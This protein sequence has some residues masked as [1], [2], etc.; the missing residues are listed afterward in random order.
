M[1]IGKYKYYFR[2]PRSSVAKDVLKWLLI[3]GGIMIA[4]QS[5]HFV[6]GLI[7]EFRRWRK[8]KEKCKNKVFYNTFHRLLRDGSIEIST[9]NRQIHI[10]LTEKGK[11]KANWCQINDLKI[12]K[13]KK[14]DRKWRI[15]IFDISQPQLIKRDAFRGK[16]QELGFRQLQKSVWIHPFECRDEIELLRDFFGL[17]KN[18]IRLIVAQEVEDDAAFKRVFKLS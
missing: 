5:P 13:P 7:K 8:K 3:A 6:P 18:D 9:I 15:A 2:K 11:E 10:A 12:G 16:L 14:W 17:G 1:G 4:S